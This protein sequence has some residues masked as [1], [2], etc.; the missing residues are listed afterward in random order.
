M[1]EKSGMRGKRGNITPA[2]QRQ[3]KISALNHQKRFQ[4]SDMARSGADC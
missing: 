3:R 1:R 2:G 4:L